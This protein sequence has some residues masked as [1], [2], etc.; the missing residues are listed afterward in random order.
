M[1]VF[2]EMKTVNEIAALVLERRLRS[3]PTVM[4]G[5]MRDVLGEDG[6]G[7]AITRRWL[8]ANEDTGYL[9][10]SP[11]AARISEMEEL[12][13]EVPKVTL[14]SSDRETKLTLEHA[15]RANVEERYLGEISA[16]A[17]GKPAPGF[18]PRTPTAPSPVA[19]IAP[20]GAQMQSAIGDDVAVVENGETFQGKIATV[21]PNGRY[22]ISFGGPQKP[23]I[24][25]D[26]EAKDFRSLNA[27]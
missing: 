24:D 26:Y 16:P 20:A 21:Q 3:S 9:Q 25:R 23:A 13:K 5:E 18:A 10:V 1:N 7:E 4:Q 12:A 6:F 14:E 19:P 11:D 27:Q 2:K 17:T 22:K 15:N 8:V